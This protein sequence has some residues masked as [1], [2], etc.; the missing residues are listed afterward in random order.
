MTSIR[1]EFPYAFDTVEHAPVPMADGTMLSARLW[2]PRGTDPV[3]AI[4]EYL[5]YRKDDVTRWRDQ[6]QLDWLAGHG[7]ACVRVDLRGTGDSEGV[8]LGE[9]LPQELDDGAA[10]I[11]WIA[12]QPWCDGNV[13]MWGISWGG[14]NA[15]Q[16][17]SLRPPALKA[18][19]SVASTVDRYADDV[20]YRGGCVLASEMLPWATEMLARNALPPTPRIVGE[21][22]Q[23]QWM[24]RLEQT[25]PYVHDWLRHQV[26]DDFWAHGS[27]G[28]DFQAVA[29]PSLVVA[30]LADGYSNA[31]LLAVDGMADRS[32]GIVGPWSHNYPEFGD[33]GPNVGF[34]QVALRWWD[35]WLRGVDNEVAQM[36]RLRVFLQ[37]R[38]EP[39]PDHDRPRPGRWIAVAPGSAA[40][41]RW[42]PAGSELRPAAGR[43]VIDLATPQHHGVWGGSWWTV[44]EAGTGP[45][46]Q[47]EDDE[48]AQCFDGPVAT[49][50]TALVGFPI[51]EARVSAD[52]AVAT[53]AARLCDVGP[54][55]S[56]LLVSRGQLNLTHRDSHERP[57]P[58]EAGAW[59]DV[60]IRLDAAAHRLAPGHRWRLALASSHWPLAWPAPE[61]ATVSV[62]AAHTCLR[63][64]VIDEVV[65]DDGFPDPPE[66]AATDRRVVRPEFSDVEIVRENGTVRR[67][68]RSG[69]GESVVDRHDTR[70]GRA[71]VDEFT[72]G[73]D[74]PQSAVVR[75]TRSISLRWADE[76]VRVE[77]EGR[78]SSDR[79]LFHVTSSLEAWRGDE[80]VF[81]RS[82]TEAIPR[83][84]V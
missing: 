42:W 62:D 10:V 13:G 54:D 17:A 71:T 70:L 20:H 80:R 52:R 29:V 61:A 7:Y 65:P 1:T 33:P 6:A 83:R 73:A 35:H 51:L 3:P 46:D 82:W 64:P 44:G 58:L 47:R 78:M 32:W 11:A 50:E 60:A 67:R 84:L 23:A 59:Y 79:D 39:S 27:I 31:P 72:I 36:P 28:D 63:L 18:V 76:A 56:S 15:L 41:E 45:S 22:W 49:E 81:E 25:P 66:I 37:D 48:L 43:G 69:A 16:V 9:Y 21:D 14:F 38:V 77:A 55:G 4:L 57:Q 34:L 40:D 8:L 26:R 74:D 53:M 12:D 2:L 24:R 5:P 19:I 75:S 30:G 68:H